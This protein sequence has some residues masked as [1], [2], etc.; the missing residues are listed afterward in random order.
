MTRRL[1]SAYLALAWCLVVAGGEWKAGKGRVGG[2][3]DRRALGQGS[4]VR[5]L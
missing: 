1:T 3:K 5:T 2:A 4:R